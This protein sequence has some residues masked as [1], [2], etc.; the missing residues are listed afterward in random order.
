MHPGYVAAI[1]AF[2]CGYA[3]GSLP[4]A[5]LLVKRERGID[6]RTA[7]GGGTGALD[8]LLVAGPSTALLAVLVEVLKG[9]VVGIAARLI[10]PEPWFI[11]T[12]IA[13]CV[14]G[15]AFPLG[16]RRGGRGLVPLVSGL[17]FALPT[18]GAICFVLAIPV[19]LLTRGRGPLYDVTVA[20]AVPLGLL[21]ASNDWRVLPA[22]ALMVAALVVRARMRRAVRARR[23]ASVL[24]GQDP[25]VID[26]RTPPGSP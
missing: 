6:L 22:A 18:A 8:A 19:M 25:L 4:V 12:A 1:V 20:I 13:G 16:F 15:D 24:V 14:A 3:I 21:V 17:L 10:S 23:R 9:G 7:G 2:V 26:Q 5:W 11:A